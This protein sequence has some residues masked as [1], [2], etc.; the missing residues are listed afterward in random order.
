MKLSWIESEVHTFFS[1]NQTALIH[2][3]LKVKFSA[4][5]QPVYLPSDCIAP[6]SVDVIA[7]GHGAINDHS[8][9]SSQ[10]NYAHLKT[11][12]RNFC[13]KVFPIVSDRESVL[14]AANSERIQSVCQG[15][16][17]GPLVTSNHTLI[18]IACFVVQ[19]KSNWIVNFITWK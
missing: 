2:L 18:G 11:T 17:G 4:Y 9:I 12:S 14:C 15:D 5:I 6:K 8:E 16:S 1:L 10:L 3:P 19:G 13:R 7:V